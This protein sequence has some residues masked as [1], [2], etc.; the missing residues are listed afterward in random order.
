MAITIPKSLSTSDVQET[1]KDLI[2]SWMMFAQLDKVGKFNT[3]SCIIQIHLFMK[4]QVV[5]FV[6]ISSTSLSPIL[7]NLGM[8]AVLWI[9]P[10]KGLMNLPF[11][12]TS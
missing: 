4:V 2:I 10:V 11:L 9:L 5:M 6:D 8:I 1:L 12:C 3:G 7:V